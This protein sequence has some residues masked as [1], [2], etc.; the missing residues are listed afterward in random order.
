MTDYGHPLEFGVFPTPD[1]ARAEDVLEIAQLAD[2][3]GLDLVSVQDHPYQARHLDTWT[4]LSVIGARTTAVRLA[5]NVANLPLRPP[6]VLARSVATL[7]LLTGGRVEL[8]LGTG[9]FWD[10]I[11]AAGGRRLSPGEAVEGLVEA[12]EIIRGLWSGQGSVRVD[13]SVH[14]VRGLHAGPAPAHPVGI[15][16]G[17]YKPRMLRV[18]GR[19]ADG[20]LPSMGYADPDALGPMNATIDEAAVAAGRAPEDV[21]RLYNVFP[22]G[23]SGG[24]LVGGPADWVEQLAGLTLEHGMST[25]VLAADDEDLVRVW[26]QEVAP[27]VREAVEVERSRVADGSA[28]DGTRPADTAGAAGVDAGAGAAADGVRGAETREHPATH[29]NASLASPD[30]SGSPRNVEAGG[31]VEIGDLRTTADDGTRLTGDLPWDEPARP[32]YP[33]P[34]DGHEYAP[35]ELAVPRNLVAIHDHLRAE[36]DQVRDIVDQV[37]RGAMTVG[38]ARSHINA[39]TMRQNQWTLGAYCESYCRVVTQHHTIEDVSML[40]HLREADPAVGPVVDRLQEEHEVIADVLDDVDRALVA[41]VSEDD[42]A[43]D[44]L[45]HV[46]DLLTDVL[47]SHLAYEERELAHP[48]AR[49]GMH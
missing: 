2:V 34:D 12:V 36:L 39:M 40:P 20:W 17:A 31:V 16:L 29:E 38:S 48:L 47:R 33:V 6:V 32:R 11:E 22:G 19:I 27:A 5:P 21:R 24:G 43:M 25:F 30:I 4:L 41:L 18:T 1:V 3:L 15:W 35:H 49:H 13:G 28:V 42:G 44:R 26:A 45:R 9:A 46:V 8:G 23:R 7:D 10:A 14:R 37:A